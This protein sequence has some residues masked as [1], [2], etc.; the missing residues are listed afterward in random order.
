MT[1]S[2]VIAVTAADRTGWAESTFWGAAWQQT[3]AKTNCNVQTAASGR[4]LWSG[5]RRRTMHLS[6]RYLLLLEQ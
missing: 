1:I 5:E 3:A 6:S 2:E 4:F